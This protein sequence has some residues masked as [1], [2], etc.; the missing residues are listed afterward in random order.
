MPEIK[1]RAMRSITRRIDQRKKLQGEIETITQT[2]QPRLDQILAK[3]NK[4]T[5]KMDKRLG[6]R[7]AKVRDLTTHIQRLVYDLTGTEMAALRRDHPT[8][9]EISGRRKEP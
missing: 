7:R 8:L 1:T 9:P 4:I 5:A 6:R 2:Y 3:L